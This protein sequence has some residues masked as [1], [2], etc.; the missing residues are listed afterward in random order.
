MDAAGIDRQIV[1]LTCPGT[2][3]LD[4]DRAIAMATLA[5]DRLAEACQRYPGRFS[6]LTGIAPQDPK[7][8]AEEIERGARRLGFNGV[9]INSHTQGEYLDDPKFWAIFEAAEALDTP[10]YLHPNTPPRNMI[11][12]MLEAG[13]DSAIYGFAVETGLHLLLDHHRRGL[14]PVPPAADRGRP[15]GGGAAVLALPAGLHARRDREG[16]P[17]RS[18]EASCPAAEPSISVEHVGD[19]QRHGVGA[20][21]HVLPRGAR[22]GRVMYAMD[23][24]Y[25]Y[26]PEEVTAQDAL[27]LD[28]A[29]K[30]RSSRASPSRFSACNPACNPAGPG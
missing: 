2:Q 16:R 19:D 15:P 12:P 8:A 11:G 25:E 9:I 30:R 13:L 17:V 21:H 6:G 28:A 14:R 7:G 10:I 1:S 22:A 24:P 5:N 27:P 29:A 4:R 3:I 23:Y 18:D 20:G 26:M